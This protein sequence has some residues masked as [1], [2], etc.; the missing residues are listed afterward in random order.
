MVEIQVTGERW[1]LLLRG[2]EEALI[3]KHIGAMSPLEF[4]WLAVWSAGGR[5]E[6]AMG[7]EGPT[8]WSLRLLDEE[9]ESEQEGETMGDR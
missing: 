8:D 1:Y 9:K 3:A 6:Q 4:M 7:V 5:V 2:S